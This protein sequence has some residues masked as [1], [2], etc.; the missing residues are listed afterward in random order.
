MRVTCTTVHGKILECVTI[1]EF[2]RKLFTNFYLNFLL[3]SVLTMHPVHSLMFHP[4]KI[5]PLTITWI[6]PTTVDRTA[7]SEHLPL[8]QTR[9]TD[10]EEL[11]LMKALKDLTKTFKDHWTFLTYP[12]YITQNVYIK[13][14][15]STHTECLYFV[16]TRN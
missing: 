7:V 4:S 8:A 1:G 6:T 5:F 14:H 12:I 2:I 3:R 11:Q 13:P 15:I 16:K 10:A 9:S